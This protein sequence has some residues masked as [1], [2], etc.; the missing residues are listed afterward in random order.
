MVNA[1]TEIITNSFIYTTNGTENVLIEI[2]RYKCEQVYKKTKFKKDRK[3]CQ[4]LT[5]LTFS[6]DPKNKDFSMSYVF[7][8]EF[9]FGH[10]G[11]VLD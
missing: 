5:R 10:C 7:F 8:R 2:I 3:T 11:Q 4:S 6:C 9:T 1:G